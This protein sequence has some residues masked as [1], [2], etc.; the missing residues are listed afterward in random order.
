MLFKK[1]AANLKKKQEFCVKIEKIII[2]KNKKKYRF[3]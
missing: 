2:K 1:I 3:N